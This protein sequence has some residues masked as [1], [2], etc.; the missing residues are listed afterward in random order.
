MILLL[1]ILISIYVSLLTIAKLMNLK[2]LL[3]ILLPPLS[4][5]QAKKE[6]EVSKPEGEGWIKTKNDGWIKPIPDKAKVDKRK[7]NQF[8]KGAWQ[9][10]FDKEGELLAKRFHNSQTGVTAFFTPNQYGEKKKLYDTISEVEK[11]LPE[12][13]WVLIYAMNQEIAFKKFE[14]FEKLNFEHKPIKSFQEKMSKKRTQEQADEQATSMFVQ[15]NSQRA[16]V[17]ETYKK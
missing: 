5:F 2:A 10:L 1:T 9:F 16:I 11:L 12:N 17:Q 15:G 7:P 14:K 13:D 6:V 3:K 4:F 8:G